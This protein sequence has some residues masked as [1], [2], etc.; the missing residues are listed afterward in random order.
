MFHQILQR[1][2]KAYQKYLRDHFLPCTVF[3]R[4]PLVMVSYDTDFT[5]NA[6]AFLAVFARS[7][8]KTIHVFLQLGWEHETPKNA[9]PFAQ[10]IKDILAQCGRLKVTVLANSENEERV[11]SALG[12]HAVFCNQNAFVDENRYPVL[13]RP[14]KFDALYI[15]RLSPFKR[16]PLAAKIKSLHLIGFKVWWIPDEEKYSEDIVSNQLKHAVWTRF[17]DAKNIP[18]EIAAARC[19]LC[20]S[21]V[22]GAM[23]V[24]IEYLL[25]G[26]PVVNTANIGGRDVLFPDF[27][28][29]TV[30]DTPEAVAAAVQEFAEHAPEPEK[31]RAAALEKMKVHR[32]TF[33][34]LLNEA[35]APKTFPDSSPLPHKLFLRCTKTPL[36]LLRYGLRNPGP[37]IPPGS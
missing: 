34:R 10:Q 30:P 12:L 8:A 20:L 25:C 15:A 35:M 7:R 22:E 14:K 33:R 17:V 3:C 24:S 26:I 32:E 9:E 5:R 16:H 23:F 13:K 36:Q 27:A 18:A 19:G 37:G 21:A 11:L 2:K 4:D 6:P 1:P 28:V 31:I 29:K